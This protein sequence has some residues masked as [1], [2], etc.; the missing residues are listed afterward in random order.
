V[1]TQTS[2]VASELVTG[3]TE[4]PSVTAS[5][6]RP[7]WA[8]CSCFLPFCDGEYGIRQRNPVPTTSRLS[9]VPCNYTRPVIS[10]GLGKRPLCF[11]E[12]RTSDPRRTSN[13]PPL[14]GISRTG[15]GIPACLNSAARPAARLSYP[16]DVQYSIVI[17][18]FSVIGTPFHAVPMIRTTQVRSGT[19]MPNRAYWHSATLPREPKSRPG[20]SSNLKA[21]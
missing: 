2:R 5:T 1:V 9:R 15:F 7:D 18:T 8:D 19:A 14:P 3:V 16:Q 12:K 11:L 4:V 17:S 6:Q 13:T 21:L 20:Q 10:P